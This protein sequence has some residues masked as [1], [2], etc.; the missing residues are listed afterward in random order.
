MVHKTS[1]VRD[2]SSGQYA[3]LII[4]IPIL[5]II[6]AL[7]WFYLQR[8]TV[9][10]LYFFVIVVFFLIIG[11]LLVL[12]GAL[13]HQA[14]KFP[15]LNYA[16]DRV[17][18]YLWI[19]GFVYCTGFLGILCWRIPYLPL[20]I[21]IQYS[22]IQDIQVGIPENLLVYPFI[23]FVFFCINT[24]ASNFLFFINKMSAYLLSSA[25][26][27]VVVTLSL[28]VYANFLMSHLW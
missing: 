15:H 7:L 21:P 18:L 4:A 28:V 2:V 26:L 20:T 6:E 3:P 19:T 25:S 24:V 14:G 23:G 17:L 9:N 8:M 11:T 22:V 13:A 16:N 1:P 27:V 5:V 12:L 10:L